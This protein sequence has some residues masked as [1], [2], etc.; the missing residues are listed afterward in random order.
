MPA[1]ALKS[2]RSGLLATHL[3]TLQ[4]ASSICSGLAL[5]EILGTGSEHTFHFPEQ[6]RAVTLPQMNA[7]IR[8]LLSPDAVRTILTVEGKKSE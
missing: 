3:T 6:L 8:R 1:E 7:Y 2:M 4:S 5:D